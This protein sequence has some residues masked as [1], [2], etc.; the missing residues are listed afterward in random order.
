MCFIN[1]KSSLQEKYLKDKKLKRG[2]RMESKLKLKKTI[3]KTQIL[4][5]I[6]YPQ[7]S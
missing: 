7:L 4:I 5:E 1:A 2:N 3:L 6:S